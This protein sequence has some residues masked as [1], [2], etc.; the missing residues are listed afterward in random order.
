M[1]PALVA[2]FLV[3]CATASPPPEA[4]FSMKTYQLAILRRGPSWS[5]EKTPERQKLL[6]GHM[7]N[8]RRLAGLG[9]L[10]I[11]GPFDVG[12]DA[13]RDAIVGLYIFDVPTTAEAEA[14][15]ATDPTIESGHFEAQV[16]PWFGPAGLTYTGRDEQVRN[17][18]AVVK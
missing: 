11:A 16:M 15:T 12:K 9:K 18:A 1:R 3:A 14:L 10:L 5:A 13:P 17:A 4:K 8:I 6:D 7:A 2:L